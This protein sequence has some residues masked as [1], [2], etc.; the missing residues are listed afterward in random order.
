MI[1]SEM[2]SSFV[3]ALF[4]LG[5]AGDI[6]QFRRAFAAATLNDVY[7]ICAIV[8][9]LPLELIAGSLVHK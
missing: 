4:S 5:Q 8:V 6:A 2:G 9:L 7:N 1:G 3:N